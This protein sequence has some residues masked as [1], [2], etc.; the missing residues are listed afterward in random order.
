MENCRAAACSPGS[1]LD[2]AVAGRGAADVDGLLPGAA[3]AGAV[4]VVVPGCTGGGE[5]LRGFQALQRRQ[6]LGHG[7][8][9]VPRAP[10]SAAEAPTQGR[11]LVASDNMQSLLTHKRI[12]TST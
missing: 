5:P 9:L 4:H 2:D 10:L 7:V 1:L 12:R 11:R 8:L 3:R 6:A